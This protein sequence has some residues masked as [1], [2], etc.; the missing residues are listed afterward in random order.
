MGFLRLIKSQMPSA[1]SAHAPISLK[2]LGVGFE[3]TRPFGRE[4][5]SLRC[6]PVPPSERANVLVVCQAT[7]LA[8]HDEEESR[9][10]MPTT[11]H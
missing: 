10:A 3:P 5:L 2:M 1:N 8:L 7:S 9:Q 4:I 6:L 11:R